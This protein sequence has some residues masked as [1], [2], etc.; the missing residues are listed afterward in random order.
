MRT[1]T[2]RSRRCSPTCASCSDDRASLSSSSTTPRRAQ[3]ASVPARP[4]AAAP[5][6]M[7]AAEGSAAA[8][9]RNPGRAGQARHRACRRASCGRRCRT[10]AA[11]PAT[12]GSCVKGLGA[13][14]GRRRSG[15]P[16]RTR[17][18][19]GARTGRARQE[20]RACAPARSTRLRRP[21]APCLGARPGATN[22]VAR[23][24]VRDLVEQIGLLP[25]EPS[26]RPSTDTPAMGPDSSPAGAEV[27]FEAPATPAKRRRKGRHHGGTG[28][29]RGAGAASCAAPAVVQRKAGTMC[30]AHS[31]ICRISSS[32]DMKP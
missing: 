8:R 28:R 25:K 3:V 19:R 31:S 6:S 30:L 18:R 29:A 10:T 32:I 5:S 12:C 24:E 4:C 17:E 1:P 27:R 21:A 26:A 23:L 15:P 2:A 11:A 16:Q 13:P 22:P 9:G 7:P 20:K 14:C